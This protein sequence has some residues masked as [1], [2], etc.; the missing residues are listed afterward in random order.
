M[1]PVHVFS[2]F[3]V[4]VVISLIV[5]HFSSKKRRQMLEEWARASG[6]IFSPDKDRRFHKEFPLPCFDRGR[7]RY[8]HNLCAGERSAYKVMAGD[9]HYTTG[10]GKSKRTHRFS[11]FFFQPA[12]PLREFTL[13][14]ENT[15][16]KLTAAFGFDDIDFES[17]EF[18]DAFH[19]SS[20]DK[21]WA[22]DILT[23]RNMELL[24]T[25]P[26][27]HLQS[28][29]SGLVIRTA[30]IWDIAEFESFAD[31]AAAFLDGIPNH[32]RRA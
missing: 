17:V 19:V 18:S 31:Y 8:A 32:I 23:P 5:G 13:R 21:K 10:S 28:D 29:P 4:F 25:R 16:D 12:F 30:E 9:Y 22:Y 1:E 2:I 20:E 6:M 15:F 26:E 14:P 27:I 24:L 7:S 11:F 3:A